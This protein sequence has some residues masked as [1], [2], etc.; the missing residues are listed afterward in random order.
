MSKFVGGLITGSILT[1][2]GIGI[3]A[4]ICDGVIT[5]PF[6][7]LDLPCRDEEKEKKDKDEEESSEDDTEEVEKEEDDD[8]PIGDHL[9]EGA[10]KLGGMLGKGLG[11]IIGAVEAGAENFEEAISEELD[12]SDSNNLSDDEK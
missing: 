4:A 8:A 11:A 1:L 9:V 6:E 2:A 12:D 7:D 3:A 5:N 10:G